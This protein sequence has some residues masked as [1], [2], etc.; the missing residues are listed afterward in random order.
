[1][2]SIKWNKSHQMIRTVNGRRTYSSSAIRSQSKVHSSTNGSWETYFKFQREGSSSPI[3]V[4]KFTYQLM[5]QFYS[6]LT[7]QS[8]ETNSAS[9]SRHKRTIEESNLCSLM[10]EQRV[11]RSTRLQ[12]NGRTLKCQITSI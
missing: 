2:T 10:M 9:L 3:Q 1:M 12:R 5:S 4:W 8:S 6:L 7:L 11:L